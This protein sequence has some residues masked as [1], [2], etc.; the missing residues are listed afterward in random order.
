MYTSKTEVIHKLLVS[1]ITT[2]ELL[3]VKINYT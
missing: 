1:T 2:F 3:V